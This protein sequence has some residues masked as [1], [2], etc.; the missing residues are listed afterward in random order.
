MDDYV[1]V[2][3]LARVD[4]DR[5][6]ETRARIEALEG[7]TTFDVEDPLKLGVLIE[8]TTLEEAH[9]RFVSQLT[10][11]DGVL[12]AW[13]VSVDI[14]QAEDGDGPNTDGG[15]TETHGDAAAGT[16]PAG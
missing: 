14:D 2:G 1:V 6:Q 13:P 8:A 4:V 12:G 10:S 5:R 16:P 3:A 15:D 7:F 9:A 11:V